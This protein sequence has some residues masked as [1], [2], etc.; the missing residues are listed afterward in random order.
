MKKANNP[1]RKDLPDP[2]LPQLRKEQPFQTAC[3]L[4][5]TADKILYSPCY[6]SSAYQIR[7]TIK[8]YGY[9]ITCVWTRSGDLIYLNCPDMNYWGL[10]LLMWRLSHYGIS[11]RYSLIDDRFNNRGLDLVIAEPLIN[12]I[13]G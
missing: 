1:S 10:K 12:E 5:V 6:D 4:P 8:I 9:T 7:G 13:N 11:R 3:G 2:T